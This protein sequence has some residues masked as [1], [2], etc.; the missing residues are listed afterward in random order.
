[1]LGFGQV[2]RVGH[3]HSTGDGVEELLEGPVDRRLSFGGH[4]AIGVGVLVGVVGGGE[5]VVASVDGGTAIVADDIHGEDGDV[6]VGSGHTASWG[7]IE[8]G[9]GASFFRDYLFPRGE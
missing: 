3:H 1:M 5:G 8:D 4:G 6:G 9:C 7:C 2:F